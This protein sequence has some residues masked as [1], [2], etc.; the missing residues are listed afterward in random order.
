MR[1]LISLINTTLSEW[2][3]FNSVRQIEALSISNT[4]E[5]HNIN[6][7]VQYEIDRTSLMV[8][9]KINVKIRKVRIRVVAVNI[10]SQM[11]IGCAL[12]EHRVSEQL[13]EKAKAI[14]LAL[15]K[16]K[17][18][19]WRKVTI[20]TS[21]RTP[22]HKLTKGSNEDALIGII[23]EDIINLKLLFDDC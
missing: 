4:G 12:V 19:G 10:N 15:I 14:R 11:T 18:E 21:C 17:E 5:Q 6:N 1:N 20:L 13:I 16:A 3:E 7:L 9:A 2:L 23:L 22:A 8:M